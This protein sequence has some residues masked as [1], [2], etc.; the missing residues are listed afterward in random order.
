MKKRNWH[1]VA[2]WGLLIVV[3]LV[4]LVMNVLTTL[5]EDDMLFSLVEG[6]Y[7]P[8]RSMT[9][10]VRSCVYH[11]CHTNGRLADVV[12][13]FFCALAGKAA[14]NVCNTLVFMALLHLLSLLVT[15]RRSLLPVSLFLAT[16]GTCFPVPGETML[17]IAGSA[18]YMWAITLSLA[19]V[20]Y[21]QRPYCGQLG[22][23]KALGVLAFGILAGG[24]N[25]ATSFGFF[26]GLCVYYAV[27][28]HLVDRRVM[29]AL[30]GYL[31]GIGII[32]ASPGA[33]QRVAEG[34]I[35]LDMTVGDLLASRWF[36]FHEKMW[37][38][39]TPVVA[40][41]VGIV[42]LLAKRGG[43]V[44]RCVWTYIAVALTLVMFALGII[45]ERAYAPLATVTF[46]IVVMAA[47]RL[48][49]YPGNDAK[50]CVSRHP[51]LALRAAMVL[52][53]LSLTVFT[54]GRG[55]KVLKRYQAYDEKTVQEIVSAPEQAV[56]LQRTFDTYNRFLDPVNYISTNFFDHEVIYCAYF[57]KEN[58]QFVPDSV[59]VRYHE[60]RLLDGAIQLPM[61]SD[62]PD[63]TG[64]I[65]II[66][67]QYYMTVELKTDTIPHS[68]QTARYYFTSSAGLSQ[69]EMQ[70]RVNYGLTK[71]YNP[72]GFFPLRYQGRILLVLPQP[73]DV[74][75]CIV[76]PLGMDPE[77]GEV[78]LS[79]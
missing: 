60:G 51:L 36:I 33:W 20:Y 34:G 29:T 76:I 62:R 35:A 68:F 45:H 23:G 28:R 58:V 43:A 52:A 42:A 6:D 66:P 64:V 8:V 75:N 63:I 69:E 14:F 4:F 65:N 40:L 41:L 13:L 46:I 73:A 18:G 32:V 48:T 1:D 67:G 31:L 57:G 56:L 30:A 61:E 17:W 39:I 79:F 15:G 49:R 21:L 26:G 19:F 7:S 37:R 78:T 9:D 2:Y 47:D 10:I 25:E 74:I 70:R 27:N 16:V 22:W 50:S 72:M 3:G 24:F 44:R 38:F 5:K 77:E 55:I 11:Y 53:A 54:Y 59:Y 71:E 12:P